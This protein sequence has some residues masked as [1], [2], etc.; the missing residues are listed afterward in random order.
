[1]GGSAKAIKLQS[2]VNSS[3][4]T[5]LQLVSPE[6][7]VIPGHDYEVVVY[8]KSDVAGKGRISFEGLL[9]NTPQ[10]DWMNLGVV[11]ETFTTNLSW[12]EIRF[13]VSDFEGDYFR[14]KFDLGYE[15]D[16][17][18][19][20]DLENLYVYDT[21]GAPIVSNL[22]SGGDF[23]S[24]IAW[25]GWGNNSTR[26]V[27]AE[28]Q[29]M[30]NSRAFFVTNPSLTGGFWEVQSTYPFAEPLE[31]GETYNLSFWVKG[32]NS[33]IIRPELQS[34]NFSSNGF[35]MV[36]VTE[37]WQHVKLSTTATTA[38]RIRLIISYGE[39]AGTV[40]MD[41]FVLSSS[42]VQGGTTT[43]VPRTPAE[44]RQIVGTQMEN[45]ISGMVT[46]ASPYVKTWNVVNEPMD[47]NNPSELRSG[48]GT[49]PGTG[50]F[51][52]QDYLG[53]E[54]GVKAFQLARNHGN[55]SD[56]LFINDSGLEANL[57]KCN[58]L[59]AYV[60]YLEDH[61]A[62]V[63]G[64]VTTMN[65]TLD[66]NMENIAIMFQ[67][68]SATGKKIR[69]SGLEIRLMNAQPSQ[70]MLMRQSEMYKDV[71]KLYAQHVPESQQYGITLA[72]AI[73]SSSN[74]S[75]RQ[76][77]W[78]ANLTRKPSYAGFATGLER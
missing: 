31:Q 40:Y 3:A 34:A 30:N 65:L 16:V 5:D 49:S 15:S 43:I 56:L 19:Y 8:I 39:F 24:G 47:D 67:R 77:L 6:I 17:T 58:G 18:Y 10:R 59:I 55:P 2:G 28:G 36:Y 78:N 33:G 38:D 46:A 23:E 68:L 42:A 13:I 35:G 63:D 4:A 62:Q 44:K 27:T 76:G 73:D 64:I 21:K 57:D 61:G 53:K 1:M 32:T 26:N 72:G 74:S 37:E 29:G 71:L 75:W 41:D 48:M 60:A 50:V 7:S 9:D 25:G 12:G 45:W 51:Y 66:S 14:I 20:I 22:I 11:T 69:V 54:Y 52:W 70:E